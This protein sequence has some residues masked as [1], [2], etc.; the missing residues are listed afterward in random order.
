MFM[1]QQVQIVEVL[2]YFFCAEGL[3]VGTV[4]LAAIL[5]TDTAPSIHTALAPETRNPAVMTGTVGKGENLNSVL[6]VFYNNLQK[7]K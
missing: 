6:K 5:E 7:T 2:L 1:F 4:T 3:G